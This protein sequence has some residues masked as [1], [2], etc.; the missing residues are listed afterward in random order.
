MGDG[1]LTLPARAAEIFGPSLVFEP[2]FRNLGWWTSPDDRAAWTVQVPTGGRYE[3]W[4]DWSCPKADAGN[5]FT[6]EVGAESITGRVEATGGWEEYK[7]AKVG[8]LPLDAAEQRLTVRP[9]MGFKGI[10]MDLRS[11]RLIPVRK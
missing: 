9:A 11:V 4:I 8:E 1:S 5:A 10:L 2:Q 3:V 6:V 7:Q